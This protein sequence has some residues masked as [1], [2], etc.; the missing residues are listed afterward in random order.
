MAEL[1]TSWQPRGAWDGILAEGHHGAP[2]ASGVIVAARQGLG[3]ASIIAGDAGTSALADAVR[4]RLGLELP[5]TPMAAMSPCHSLVWTGPGQ[6]LLVAASRDGIAEDLEAVSRL[7]TVSA[8]SDGRAALRLSGAMVRKALAKGCMVDLH[9]SAFP[10]G[11]AALTSIAYIGVHLWR[12]ADG[13]DGS[14]FEVMIPRSM[15]GSF[16]SW[17]S[18]SAAEFGCACLEGRG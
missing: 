4:T 1:A 16:W 17:L 18:A 13:P 3:I 7:A 2:G 10:V 12:A 6:W 9:P 5:T 14:V 8:Q 15:A 11:M